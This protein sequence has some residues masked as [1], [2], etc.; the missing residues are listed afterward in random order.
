MLNPRK[1][2]EGVIDLIT[3]SSVRVK[4]DHKEECFRFIDIRLGWDCPSDVKV[5]EKIFLDYIVTPGYGLWKG[6]RKANE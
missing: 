5:G 4:T 2:I 1:T 6:R 3:H